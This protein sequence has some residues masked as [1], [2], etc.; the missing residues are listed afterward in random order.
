[1]KGKLCF[2]RIVGI[3]SILF[4]VFFLANPILAETT[5][6]DGNWEAE[7]LQDPD[8]AV[9]SYNSSLAYYDDGE[10]EYLMYVGNDG[11]IYGYDLETEES[12]LACDAP[13][14]SEFFDIAGLFVSDDEYLYFHDNGRFLGTGNSVIF[15]VDLSEPWPA[16]Y[17]RL[18]T[19]SLATVFSFTQNLKDKKVWFASAEFGGPNFCLSEVKSKFNSV[20][21][22]VTIEKQ[23]PLNSGNGPIAF[24]DKKQI[25]YGES[26]FGGDGF[27]HRVSVKKKKVV[28]P[29]YLTFTGG[30]AAA[31]FDPSNTSVIYVGTGGGQTIS[32]LVGQDETVLATTEFNAT[33]L[34]F[35]G[36][37]L[38]VGEMD[39]STGA[40]T[41]S[42]LFQT[43]AP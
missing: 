20:K 43:P 38:Y 31:T 23:D 14:I 40:V 41:F 1:M 19:D 18:D 16:Y 37:A 35:G 11:D 2:G 5:A 21:E 32:S 24:L 42:K 10:K 26:I 12:T 8:P 13:F 4:V 9:S 36:G 22:K 39:V 25:L 7:A 29:D 33:G 28:E 17:E 30:L 15:R 3:G 27:F 6:V 34:T